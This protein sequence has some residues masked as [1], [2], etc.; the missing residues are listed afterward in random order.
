LLL[1][2]LLL[3]VRLGL[4]LQIRCVVWILLLRSELVLLLLRMVSPDNLVLII[5][6]FFI[7]RK[8]DISSSVVVSVWE[9]PVCVFERLV[10][11][12]SFLLVDGPV[13]I[14]VHEMVV[15]GLLANVV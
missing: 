9:I 11:H 2:G 3:G 14:I 10:G 12:L 13:E 5:I 4:G 15:A 6:L 7:V 1:L 8:D